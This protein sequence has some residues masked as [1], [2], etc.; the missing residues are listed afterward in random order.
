MAFCTRAGT[1]RRWPPAARRGPTRRRWPRRPGPQSNARRELAHAQCARHALL[2]ECGKLAEAETEFRTALAI[3]GSWP[4]RIPGT[5]EFRSSLADS[6]CLPRRRAVEHGQ[7]G[8]SR[9]RD[10]HGNGNRPETGGRESRRHEFPTEASRSAGL[11]LGELLVHSGQPAEAEA[12]CRTGLAIV[13]EAGGRQSR[14]HRFPRQFW[15]SATESRRP[16]VA[17]GQAGGGGGR[18]LA[19]RWRSCRS[20]RTR[21]PRSP[22]YPA[23]RMRH[24]G[25]GD[26][27]P[28]ARAGRPRP[29]A[30]Y[31][32]AIALRERRL[33]VDPPNL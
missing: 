9:G 7:A 1:T 15:R 25:L 19:R 12:E 11:W 13:A 27:R 26:V 29:R 31:D 14:R 6:H 23:P 17:A 3:F 10:P 24:Y 33:A 16:T 30:I 28:L 8:G 32:R 20:S 21:I 18:V 2:C 4:T 5:L 22:P